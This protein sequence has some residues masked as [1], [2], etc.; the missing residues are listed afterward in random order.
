LLRYNLFCAFIIA[1]ELERFVYDLKVIDERVTV[2]EFITFTF[3][4]E[5]KILVFN[6]LADVWFGFLNAFLE[7]LGELCLRFFQN[8]EQIN[9]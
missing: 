1:I 8:T 2:G 3:L 9:A 5:V 6:E 4:V 7:E